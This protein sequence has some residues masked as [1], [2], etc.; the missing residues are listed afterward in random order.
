MPPKTDLKADIELLHSLEEAQII[1]QMSLAKRI[2]IS[3]GFTNTLLKRAI[4]KGYIKAKSAP[5]KR[6]SYYLT[7]KG[8]SEKSRLII[9]YL[10]T[11]LNFFRK[12]KQEYA[13]LLL[14]AKSQNKESIV[15]L[16]SG[17]LAEIAIMASWDA[18]VT[19][20]AIVCP[21]TE[22]KSINNIPV[23]RELSDLHDY[24]LLLLSDSRNPQGTFDET[25]SKVASP[26][27]IATPPF[28]KIHHNTVES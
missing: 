8:F 4:H 13:S 25:I 1:S 21:L 20:S 16:G 12:A 6:Y 9:E 22:K 14:R 5:Y 10:E 19:I 15:L 27:M 23:H 28:L 17:E 7:P 24:D 26:E 18:E 3:I 11:S 2:G